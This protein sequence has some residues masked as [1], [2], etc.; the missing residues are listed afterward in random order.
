MK[1]I[2]LPCMLVALISA[3]AQ[4][5]NL[6]ADNASDPAYSSGWLD[7]SNGGYGFGAWQ[8]IPSTPGPLSGHFIGSSTGNGDGLDNG[9]SGGVAN[10][11]DIDTG[12]MI[13]VSWGMY[14]N[15]GRNAVA[16]R[17]FTGGPL[18]VG[19]TFSVDF[20]NGWINSTP[21]TGQIDIGLTDSANNVIFRVSFI[22]GALNYQYADAGGIFQLSTIPFGDEGFNLS[23]T[24][25][26]PFAYSATLTRR[27]GISTNWT[28]TLN[29]APE[30]FVARNF[31]AGS[32]SA[33]DLFINS[34]SIVPEP[35]TIALAALGVI[36]VAVRAFR[37]RA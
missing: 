11:N 5:A 9:L 6:A 32:G 2:V 7:G 28:G 10:D 20:D 13:P 37:R 8:L 12:T 21:I 15:N 14:A 18:S 3:S 31:T 4:A 33:H 24:M 26:G 17:P 36:G 29:A 19:Q 30:G 35:S 1:K 25:T 16:Y 34:M 23:V 27:D 22:G